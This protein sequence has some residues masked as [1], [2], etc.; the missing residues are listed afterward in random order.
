MSQLS[1]VSKTLY[2]PMGGRIYAS[3]H[4]PNVFY[5]AKAIDLKK[6][7]PQDV[8]N[9]ALQSQYSFMASASRCKNID[10][11]IRAFLGQYPQANI[12]ELGCGL[13]TTYFRVDNGSATWYELDLPEVMELRETLIPRQERMTHLKASVFDPEWMKQLAAELNDQP[14]LFLA[15]GLFHYFEKEAVVQLLISLQQFKNSYIVF[16]AVSKSGMKGTR[17]YMK[18]MGKD[19]ALMY[20]YCDNAAD[21]AKELGGDTQL[22]SEKDFYR[23][24][25]KKGMSLLTK[26]SMRVSDML[27]MVKVIVLKLA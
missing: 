27:H 14:V 9:D 19:A 26:I 15:S 22:I 17:R 2:V 3:E 25:D 18:K 8:L 16:D 12:V 4:F 21:I 24:I 6:Q 5:D 10:D 7:I 23:N 20:F 13:E 1:E 11:S